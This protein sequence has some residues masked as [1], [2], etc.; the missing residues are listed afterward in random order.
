MSAKHHEPGDIDASVQSAFQSTERYYREQ[1]FSSGCSSLVPIYRI[2]D[3]TSTPESIIKQLDG[4]PYIQNNIKFSDKVIETLLDIT[5][6]C[7]NDIHFFFQGD[8]REELSQFIESQCTQLDSLSQVVN[9]S[10]SSSSPKWGNLEANIHNLIKQYP[11]LNSLDCEGILR[12]ISVI[13]E[14][15]SFDTNV[16]SYLE[17]FY[18]PE[19]E[20]KSNLNQS[21][22]MCMVAT[23]NQLNLDETDLKSLITL[24][25]V[26]DLGY[27][28]L[29]EGIDDFEVMHPLVSHR[30]LT[31]CNEKINDPDLI[32][33]ENLLNAVLMHH[34]FVDASGPLTRMRHPF[35]SKITGDQIPIIAQISGI[36]DLYFGFLEKYSPGLSFAITCGF[37]LGQGDVKPRYSVEVIECFMTTLKS[38][39]YKIDIEKQEAEQLM[40]AILGVLK[41]PNIR[42]K[43]ISMIITKSESWYERITLALNIVRNIA[44]MQ[45]DEMRED[46]LVSALHLPLEFG[47]N[48]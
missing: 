2:N 4:S 11:I 12:Q 39:S 47:L 29:D 21:S 42:K 7:F 40:F 24:A 37:V 19:W 18:Q 1:I 14:L 35:V 20:H 17:I 5:L 28:R 27:A 38:G 43:A 48:Y 36:C 31:E 26:K 6:Y 15:I 8:M 45:P 9:T 25:L 41:E 23:A 13:V 44:R 3:N 46:A 34:E 32:V 10:P 16:E 22:L 30:L 33:S